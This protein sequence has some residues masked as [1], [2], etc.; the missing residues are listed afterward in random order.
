[1][2][3]KFKQIPGYEGRYA[4]N[5]DGEIFSVRYPKLL[6]QSKN[7]GGYLQ[8]RI[9]GNDG[10]ASTL[11]VHRLVMLAF[12]GPLKEGHEVDHQNRIRTD[13]RLIN[14]RYCDISRG[15]Q[16]RIDESVSGYRGVHLHDGNL[17]RPWRSKIT[18]RGSQKWSGY[19]SSPM[20]AAKIYDRMAVLYFGEN[21]L[22]N[23]SLGLI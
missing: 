2:K 22:T 12:V 10:R 8:V 7:R 13:N 17:K 1:M 15:R 19:F 18:V 21:A 9:R 16:N 11:R 3:T 20:Q 6:K 14:L 5:T 23:V 4:V